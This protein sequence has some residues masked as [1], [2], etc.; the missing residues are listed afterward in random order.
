MDCKQLG[1]TGLML[2]RLGFGAF[3]I[4][5]NQGIKY[6][7]GYALPTRE[8]VEVLLNQLLDMGVTYI[9]TAPAY[10]ISEQRIG[11]TIAHRRDEFV[12]S[13]KVGERFEDGVSNYDYSKTAVRDS[14]QLSLKR[15]KTDRLDVVYVHS[16]GDDLNILQETDVVETLVGL[17]DQGVIRTIGMSGKT[18][19][20]ARAALAMGWTDAW[21]VEYNVDDTSHETLMNGAAAQGVGVVVKKGLAAGHLPAAKA[22]GFVMEQASVTSLVIGGLNAAHFKENIEAVV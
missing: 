19:E 3:K 7:T 22:I 14:V 11:E 12:L 4:G 6:P 13:T 8:E 9:D 1:N 10:G 2:S 5:R 17:R 18:V 21:M 20:G 15:L 16:N